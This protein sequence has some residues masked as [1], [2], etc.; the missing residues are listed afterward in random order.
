MLS[1]AKA[2]YKSSEFVI[3]EIVPILTN[4]YALASL[5]E[6]K[7]KI[8][9]A[10]VGFLNTCNRNTEEL[11]PVPA[12]CL[13]A[14]ISGD[15]ILQSAGLQGLTIIH[16]FAPIDIRKSLYKALK[17]L[18][19]SPQSNNLRKT[20][21]TCF[22]RYATQ[23]EA[24]I[25][26]LVQE[27]CSNG[28]CLSLYL[29]SLGYLAKNPSFTKDV[30]AV[31]TDC[32]KKS[33]EEAQVSFSCLR[34]VLERE[35]DNDGIYYCLGDMNFV[36]DVVDW[37]LQNSDTVEHKNL[38]KDVS[39]TLNLLVGSLN[40]EKQKIVVSNEYS[41]I[42]ASF[43]RK[44]LP[45]LVLLNGLLLR[46][47]R[48]FATQEILNILL[49]IAVDSQEEFKQDMAVKL[50]ANILNKTENSELL[51]ATLSNISS[52]SVGLLCWLVKALAMRNHHDLQLW[53]D[54]LFH[55]L[56][57]HDAKAFEILMMEDCDALSSNC[58]CKIR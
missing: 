41:K 10:L 40:D 5:T 57:K 33:M 46:I 6:E 49:E 43:K 18:L 25:K 45:A 51:Q 56:G 30:L 26:E 24:E 7:V 37:M 53:V 36:S 2:N 29:D 12:Y 38:L 50:L 1:A 21:L 54:R 11:N 32:C 55:S 47:R 58:F 17:T 22:E 27:M 44:E 15:S 28:H 52:N 4:T 35:A 20:A 14:I 8:L 16:N 9:E 3:K 34:R 19:T 42:E 13:E 48:D 31:I 39:K 23:Y